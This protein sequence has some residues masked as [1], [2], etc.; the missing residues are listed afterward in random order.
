MALIIAVCVLAFIFGAERTRL[1]TPAEEPSTARALFSDA[2]VPKIF[3]T[4]TTSVAA[5]NICT[6]CQGW[7]TAVHLKDSG[8]DG[9]YGNIS[10]DGGTGDALNLGTSLIGYDTIFFFMAR[11]NNNLTYRLNDVSGGST[12]M[13]VNYCVD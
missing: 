6:N 13:E 2:C 10:I 4:S 11:F 7:L 8:L 12:Y 1:T 5:G 9:G 3:Y